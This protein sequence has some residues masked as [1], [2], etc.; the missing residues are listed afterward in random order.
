MQK[1]NAKKL[2]KKKTELSTRKRNSASR[3]RG[4]MLNTAKLT[5]ILIFF[6]WLHCTCIHEFKSFVFDKILRISTAQSSIH[7]CYDEE[8]VP[9]YLFD[10][11][12]P[13]D[14][15]DT[16]KWNR[17]DLILWV[18]TP[19]HCNSLICR[20]CV[21]HNFSPHSPLCNYIRNRVH[22][23][24][25]LCI[26]R[27]FGMAFSGRLAYHPHWCWTNFQHLKIVFAQ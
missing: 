9:P 15:E 26:F 19:L 17:W 4:K 12:H 23:R 1:S 10:T 18:Y 22:C 5:V 8:A 2:M 7:S 24:Q 11:A 25:L 6:L 27:Y 20:P 13:L 21:L 3:F 16:D 14:P